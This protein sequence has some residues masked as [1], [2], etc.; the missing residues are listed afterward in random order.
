MRDGWREKE[1]ASEIRV[2][3]FLLLL[4]SFSMYKREREIKREK[5]SA[6]RR[7]WMIK[8]NSTDLLK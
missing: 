4:S 2:R 3:Y 7:F 5:V 1:G 8:S 6:L